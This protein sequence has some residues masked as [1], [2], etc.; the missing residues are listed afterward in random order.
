MRRNSILNTKK[1][2]HRAAMKSPEALLHSL[3]TTAAAL[4]SRGFDRGELAESLLIRLLTHPKDRAQV[5][6]LY[7]CL[8]FLSAAYEEASSM[9]S[10]AGFLWMRFL[11]KS[12]GMRVPPGS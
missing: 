1:V 6:L 5:A 7:H 3:T 12:P 4:C 2:L 10:P 11:E 9:A 8:V